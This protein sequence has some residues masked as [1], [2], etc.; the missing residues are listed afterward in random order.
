MVCYSVALFTP[1][2]FPIDIANSASGGPTG[3]M[4]TVF[5]VLPYILFGLVFVII[6]LTYSFYSSLDSKRNPCVR[7]IKSIWKSVLALLLLIV[8]GTIVYLLAGFA[9]IRMRAVASDP[10]SAADVFS[11]FEQE[12]SWETRSIQMALPVYLISFVSMFGYILLI[13]FAGIGFGSLPMSL[14]RKFR[15]RPRPI[16]KKKFYAEK[17][18]LKARAVDLREAAMELRGGSG[19]KYRSAKSRIAHAV[20]ALE[21]EHRTLMICQGQGN[22]NPLKYWGALLL[23]ILLLLVSLVCVAHIIVCPILD[24]HPFLNYAL[25]YL[26]GV[27]DMLEIAVFGLLALYIMA[28]ALSG[29]SYFGF[30]FI[31]FIPVHPLRKGATSLAGILFNLALALLAA[32]AVLPLL[33][34]LFDVAALGS[35][36]AMMYSQTINMRYFNY[37]FTYGLFAIVF[38]FPVSLVFLIILPGKSLE[39]RAIEEARSLTLKERAAG[40]RRVRAATIEDARV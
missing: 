23:G 37:V 22:Y 11:D 35:G 12:I 4:G 15:F 28:A 1:L 17:T 39:D 21:E 3:L 33:Q 13:V 20:Q 2:L 26:A 36:V 8:I 16:S 5:M 19:R 29:I 18:R 10:T 40:T 30:R 7:I 27:W 34:E 25:E 6:P 14:I 32:S 31:L 24:A 9:D 38:L